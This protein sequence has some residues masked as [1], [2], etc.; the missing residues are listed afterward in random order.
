MNVVLLFWILTVSS[1][2]FYFRNKFISG[3]NQKL[4]S[5]KEHIIN[6]TDNEPL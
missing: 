3:D 2:F 4:Q 1:L 5:I 6:S